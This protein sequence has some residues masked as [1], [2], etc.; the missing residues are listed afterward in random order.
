M[1]KSKV[2][3][4]LVFKREGGKLEGAVAL[5]VDESLGLGDK[6]FLYDEE[7]SWAKFLTKPRKMLESGDINVNGINIHQAD[8]FIRMTQIDKI[9]KLT[10]TT[11][12][13]EFDSQRVSVRWLSTSQSH[14]YP[15]YAPP[16]SRLQRS[17]SLRS[18]RTTKHWPSP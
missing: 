15:T 16:P 10:P 18:K 17:T 1:K 9:D 12:Q 13:K 6:T 5:Q 4:C 11:T 8:G 2:D 14:P 7:K 3:P